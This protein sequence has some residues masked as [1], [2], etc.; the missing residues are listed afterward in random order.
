MRII[1]LSFG[2]L[3]AAGCACKPGNSDGPD[4]GDAGPMPCS[5]SSDCGSMALVCDPAMHVCVTKCTTDMDCAAGNGGVC[6][7]DG[8]CRPACNEVDGGDGY[9]PDFNKLCLSRTGHCV[10][11]CTADDQCL[12]LGPAPRGDEAVGRCIGVDMV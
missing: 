5:M 2:L 9:C 6:V 4:A 12:P 8:T 3:F 11:K 1:L 7:E 10:D